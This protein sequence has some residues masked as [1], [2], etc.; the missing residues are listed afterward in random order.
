MIKK[1]IDI[2]KGVA[3][4]DPIIEKG[5]NIVIDVMDSLTYFRNILSPSGMKQLDQYCSGM[6]FG[7]HGSQMLVKVSNT[8]I[9]PVD[10][11]GK[12]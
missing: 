3:S 9:N 8:L 10:K 11:N 1:N 2:A 7:L 6:V 12:V 5:L 4:I